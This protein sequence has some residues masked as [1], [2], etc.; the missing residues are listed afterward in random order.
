MERNHLEQRLSRI[1]TSWTVL[2]QAND[3]PAD[4]AVAAQQLLLQRYGGAIYRY[5]LRAVGDPAVA[6]DLTQEFGLRLIR[7]QF[8]RADPDRGRFRDYVKTVLFHLVSKYRKGLHKQPRPMS[9]DSPEFVNLAAVP[10]DADREFDASWRDELLAR[11]WEALARTHSR[12]HAVLRLRADHPDMGSAEMA[13][14]LTQQ[15]GKPFTADAVRQNLRRARETFAD[16]L[17]DE[18]AQSLEAPT[19][20]RLQEELAELTLLEYC[21]S[22]LDRLTR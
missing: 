3:G 1:S 17:L 22:A 6:D 7:G 13:A 11:A 21:R 2:R 9:T 16:L 14:Q 15:L 19:A 5:I 4:A 18:V 20:E 8:H 12:F 10:E